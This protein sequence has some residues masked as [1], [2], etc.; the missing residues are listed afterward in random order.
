MPKSSNQLVLMV[1]G[2]DVTGKTH[3][4]QG[5]SQF[6]GIPYYKNPGEKVAF[7][8]DPMW[9]H[10]TMKYGNPMLFTF[11]A[12]TGYD[13]VIDRGYACEAVY[14]PIFRGTPVDWDAIRVA[15]EHAAKL[16]VVFIIP[17]RSSYAGIQDA[18]NPEITS[19]KLAQIHAGFVHFAN[20]TQCSVLHLCVDDENLNRQIRDIEK[21]LIDIGRM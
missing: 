10:N 14:P 20:F 16:G 15:D 13:V 4:A 6:L 21:F 9:F 12:Q 2:P 1:D 18:R 5:L 8:K 19:E 3:I 17:F 11:L 7:G